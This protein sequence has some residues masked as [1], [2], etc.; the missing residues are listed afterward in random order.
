[1]NTNGFIC[2]LSHHEMNLDLA[3]SLRAPDG[4]DVQT[5]F[6]KEGLPDGNCRSL[7]V[8]LD[9][10]APGRVALQRLVK[11]LIG[12]PHP[13]PVAVFG[14]NLEDDQVMD[15]RAAG[16]QVFQHGLC[17]AVFAAIAEQ[18]SVAPSDGLAGHRPDTMTTGHH[19][20]HQADIIGEGASTWPR[21]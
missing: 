13:Y 16:I 2:F 1:M 5:R 8:D 19:F 21:S 10:V 4:L 9:S 17:P 15:L 6:L 11:E 18:L 7:V 20:C 3:L 14:Y 12:R